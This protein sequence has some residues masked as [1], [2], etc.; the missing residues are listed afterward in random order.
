MGGPAG[1]DR[2][3]V[4][5]DLRRLDRIID[6]DE[7]KAIAVVEPG[8]TPEMLM[9]EIQ[10]RRLDL[11]MDSASSPY[12][13]LIATALERGIGY[14]MAPDRFD[15]MCGAEVLLGDGTLIRTG[16]GGVP[17]STTFHTNK[18]GYGP[19]LDGLFSQSNFGI[20]TKA[21]FWLYPQPEHFRHAADHALDWIR[22]YGDRDGFVEYERLNSTP[23][24]PRLEGS[25][26]GI[27][28]ADG[29]LAEDPIAVS[30]VQGCL[31]RP[32]T[33][34][35]WTARDAG[36]QSDPVCGATEGGDAVP[37][38]GEVLLT[39]GGACVTDDAYWH[40]LTCSG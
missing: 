36:D 39:V 12:G 30:E 35:G 14:G 22:D 34:S 19:V 24:Y 37:L 3:G 4:A 15:A 18:Y 5:V 1:V 33:K 31:Y 26:D 27:S 2:G 40:G 29:H 9:A 6:I 23:C 11:W 38:G 21:G 8:V 20:V 7:K 16:T 28:S 32:Y 13:S 25:W 10:S 17:S